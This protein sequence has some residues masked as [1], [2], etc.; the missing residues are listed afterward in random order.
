MFRFSYLAYIINTILYFF[1][2]FGF[3]FQIQLST[4]NFLPENA[5]IF[6]ACKNGDVLAVL[7]LLETRAASPQDCTPQ[8][9]TPLRVGHLSQG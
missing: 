7:N 5:E 6:I 8:F 9:S 1:R 4:R 3:S 2:S